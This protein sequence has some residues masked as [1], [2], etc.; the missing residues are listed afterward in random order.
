MDDMKI[1]QLYN[2]RDETAINETANKY[3]RLLYSIAYNLLSNHQDSEEIVNH[4]YYKAW[5]A[6][7]P[8]QPSSIS[9]YL[10]RITRNLS[11]NRWHEQKTQKRNHGAKLILSELSDCIPSSTTVET[12]IEL[13]ELAEIINCWLNDLP[14]DSRYF[15]CEDIGLGMQ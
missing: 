5:D 10:A 13:N 2:A 3:G 1:I 12:E 14:V 9:A 15:F 6:I 8:Q 7:P 4:T 11:I